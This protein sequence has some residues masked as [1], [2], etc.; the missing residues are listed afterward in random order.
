M[1]EK[2]RLVNVIPL[3]AK[4]GGIIDNMNHPAEFIYQN[5]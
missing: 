5:V 1:F 3:V 2:Y 4:V